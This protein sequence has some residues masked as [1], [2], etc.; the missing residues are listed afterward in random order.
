MNIL[1]KEQKVILYLPTKEVSIQ[2]ENSPIDRKVL[3]D[4][5]KT[6]INQ[7]HNKK[8]N[9]YKRIYCISSYTEYFPEIDKGFKNYLPFQQLQ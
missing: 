8:E 4:F 7:E 3:L 9:A 2:D 1:A 6:S 5:E